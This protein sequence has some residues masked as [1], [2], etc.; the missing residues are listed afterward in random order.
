MLALGRVLPWR[1]VLATAPHR[2]AK[3]KPIFTWAHKLLF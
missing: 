3:D 1:D 2:R